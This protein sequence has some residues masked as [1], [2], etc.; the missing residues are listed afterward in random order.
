MWEK[1]LVVKDLK[2]HSPSK[3]QIIVCILVLS[4]LILS[5]YYYID[6]FP[7]R[8]SYTIKS[9]YV[10]SVQ[11]STIASDESTMINLSSV[12]SNNNL[13]WAEVLI[14]EKF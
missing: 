1:I 11:P 8:P 9:P 13:K 7:Q 4:I 10:L 5:V 2:N 12:I 14:A 3:I 6:N